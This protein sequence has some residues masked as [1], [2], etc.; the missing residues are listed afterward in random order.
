[1][2]SLKTDD[3]VIAPTGVTTGT[4]DNASDYPSRSVLT[5]LGALT[6]LLFL[7]QYT[8][9]SNLGSMPPNKPFGTLNALWEAILNEDVLG[10][11]DAALAVSILTVLA[12]ILALE[13]TQGRFTQT[14]GWGLARERRTLIGLTLALAVVSRYYLAA[15][16]LS[17]AADSAHHLTYAWIASQSI[18]MGELPIWTNYLGAG[19]PFCQFYGFAYFYLVG[20]VSLVFRDPFLSIKLVLFLAH[21]ASGVGMYLAARSVGHDRGGGV[22]AGLAYAL[23]FWHVQQVL[24]MGRLPVSLIY[25]FLPWLFHAVHLLAGARALSIRTLSLG[26]LSLCLLTFAHPGYAF[27]SILFCCLYSAIKAITERRPDIVLRTGLMLFL[28]ILAGAYLSVPMFVE[29]EFSGLAEGIALSWQSDPTW[30]HLLSWSNYRYFPAGAEGGNWYGGYLGLSII[31]AA[32]ITA[33]NALT[34][35]ADTRVTIPSLVCLFGSLILVFGYRWP[36]LT[37]SIT[38]A[39]NAGRYLLFTSFFLC[40][41]SAGA[42]LALARIWPSFHKTRMCA[43]LLIL[44]AVDLGPTTIQQP[45]VLGQDQFLFDAD[46]K[47]VLNRTANELADLGQIPSERVL[48]ASRTFAAINPFPG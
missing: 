45:Y 34:R 20:I 12:G 4:S 18:Q 15:G 26:M 21:V 39:F 9:L 5:L 35:A 8:T 1:M 40:L 14:I 46:L 33:Y 10:W 41:L 44:M 2:T 13:V 48:H 17:W 38:H 29:R 32:G 37:S 27:W 42:P 43:L 23:C 47:S 3:A 25:A 19:T 24:I 7:M 11:K 28:G 22:L 30:A 36:I 6:V 31:L 16:E